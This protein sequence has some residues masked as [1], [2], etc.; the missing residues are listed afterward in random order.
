MVKA[1]K[2][3]TLGPEAFVTAR[4]AAGYAPP[5]QVEE[6]RGRG[7]LY[8]GGRNALLVGMK[9]IT[10]IYL[11]QDVAPASI[12]AQNSSSA[13]KYVASALR[14]ISKLITSIHLK[15]ATTVD[16]TD[17]MEADGIGDMDVS[18]EEVK[19]HDDDD[20]DPE[21]EGGMLCG[22]FDRLARKNVQANSLNDTE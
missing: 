22:C 8:E 11:K 19:S 1:T 18:D 5:K 7:R 21:T 15:P 17:K 10:N 2:S 12:G 4:A 20:S 13:R 14:H 9:K 6:H 3:R 16:G